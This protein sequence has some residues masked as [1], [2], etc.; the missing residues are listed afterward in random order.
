M[1]LFMDSSEEEINEIINTNLMGAIYLSK[2]ALPHMISRKCYIQ[3]QKEELIYLQKHLQ[4][5]WLCQIL[6]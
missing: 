2:E 1:G 4:K 6:E 5:K 3:Q